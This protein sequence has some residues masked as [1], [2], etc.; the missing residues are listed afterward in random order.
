MSN[1]YLGLGTNQGDRPVL[2]AQA[3]NACEE[4]IGELLASSA[5]YETAAWGLTDQPDFLNLCI[6]LQTDLPPFACLDLA[7]SIEAD[8]GREREIHWGPRSMDIDMLFYDDQVY[9]D[10]RLSL[11]H[12]YVQERRFVLKPLAEI[13]GDLVHPKYDKT[14]IEL[15]DECADESEVKVFKVVG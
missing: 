3:V 15:L 1:L 12:P 4:R 7:L 6:H 2:L 9:A 14:V 8:L 10:H 11:P 5:I 13:A